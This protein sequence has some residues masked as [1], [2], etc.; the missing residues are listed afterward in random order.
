MSRS[1]FQE[2]KQ[3]FNELSQKRRDELLRDIYKFSN[4]T[5]LFLENRLLGGSL[6]DD[7]VKQMERETIT[8]VYKM[9][10]GDINGRVV[11]S[12]ISKAKKSGVNIWTIMKLEQLAYRGFIEFLNEYGGGPE[13]YDYMASRHFE[14][15]LKLVKGEIKEEQERIQIFTELKTYLE[16]KDNMYTDELDEIF[17]KET[18]VEV[19]RKRRY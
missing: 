5:R 17:E 2:I 9:P 10:P 15:Y 11:D 7:F 13:T 19:E 6:G 1:R 12:I 16:K 8:K 4:D 18:G 3:K 14:N